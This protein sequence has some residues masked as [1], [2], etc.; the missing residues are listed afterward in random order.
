MSSL[1]QAN[2]E[3]D[4]AKSDLTKANSSKEKVEA[5]CRELQKENRRMKDEN[6]RL[7]QSQENLAWDVKFKTEQDANV[8]AKQDFLDEAEVGKMRT[9]V[10]QYQ[11][12]ERHFN[13]LMRSKDLEVQLL[14]ARLEQQQKLAEQETL[15]VS[16]SRP[17]IS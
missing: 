17:G 16:P 13:A 6:Q 2:K 15:K 10:N 4:A 7:Q 12:R 9:F 3:R 1:L 5:V 11:V 14:E 8:D